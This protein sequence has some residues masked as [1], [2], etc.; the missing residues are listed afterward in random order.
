MLSFIIS[1]IVSFLYLCF[2]F[3]FFILFVSWTFPFP[4]FFNVCKHS[5]HKLSISLNEF[6][7]IDRYKTIKQRRRRRK[8]K[9]FNYDWFYQWSVYNGIHV[10]PCRFLCSMTFWW[11]GCRFLLMFMMP[12]I[13]I[14]LTLIW[15]NKYT[16]YE[17]SL[18]TWK[19]SFKWPSNTSNRIRIEWKSYDNCWFLYSMT[20]KNL[21]SPLFSLCS[22]PLSSSSSKRG[23]ERKQRTTS[24]SSTMTNESYS[25]SLGVGPL[26][27]SWC[28]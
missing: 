1:V 19:Y 24:T 14:N 20:N 17:H 13:L 11:L 22:D 26:W 6:I 28:H 8:S 12:K 2:F 4:T 18:K 9:S 25:I 3:F 7:L 15:P 5:A 21:F 27:W 10:R 23:N 16:F